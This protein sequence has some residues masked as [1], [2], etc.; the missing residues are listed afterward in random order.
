[1]GDEIKLNNGSSP[2]DT[3]GNDW[4]PHG[5]NDTIGGIT[6]ERFDPADSSGY[7]PGGRKRRSDF[8][9]A[10]GGRPAGPG[11]S[12]STKTGKESKVALTVSA[13][14]IENIHLLA[15][16]F[17]GIEYLKLDKDECDELAKALI[18]LQTFYP[19]VDVPAK[20]M[21]WMG[22]LMVVG[23]VYGPRVILMMDMQKKQ[24]PP[25]HPTII[26]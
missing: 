25:G 16:K 7:H 9:R 20:A 2:K 26:K 3:G 21:A 18:Q 19:A 13:E 24:P 4:T 5:T 12:Q 17:S 15:A 10:K 22:L 11:N 6:S 23:K 14:V 1:M 8:G